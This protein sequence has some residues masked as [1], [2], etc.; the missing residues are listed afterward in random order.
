MTATTAASRQLA[1][2]PDD[3]LDCRRPG[4]VLY[5]EGGL[6]RFERRLGSR[7]AEVLVDDDC[8]EV[9]ATLE[10]RRSRRLAPSPS[11]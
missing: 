10:A 4:W 1:F 6:V 3:Y 8:L 9:V 7:T 2:N 5:E 11:R